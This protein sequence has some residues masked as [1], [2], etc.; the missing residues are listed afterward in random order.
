MQSVF[1]SKSMT[2]DVA[3]KFYLAQTYTEHKTSHN[4]IKA[5]DS[6]KKKASMCQ[7]AND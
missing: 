7:N 5:K 4:R 6:W 1:K 2:Y 3:S